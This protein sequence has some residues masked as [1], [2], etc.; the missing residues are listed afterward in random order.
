MTD[1]LAIKLVEI[2]HWLD[3]IKSDLPT[4]IDASNLNANSKIPFK[5]LCCQAGYL[6][7]IEELGRSACDSLDKGDV[8]ASIVLTRSLIETA[9]ALWHLKEIIARQV[10][11][12][13]EPSLDE[14]IMRLLVGSKIS[15]LLPV[16]VL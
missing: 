4:N 2:R 16:N 7:R 11:S 9:C 5:A 13:V 1:E 15:D 3:A 10:E 6:W 14:L 12:G 8:V